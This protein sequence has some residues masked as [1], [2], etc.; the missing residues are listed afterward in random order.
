MA[1]DGVD[2]TVDILHA[3]HHARYGVDQLGR[4]AH[5]VDR[6][7]VSYTHLAQREYERAR[8][9]ANDAY[10]ARLE[11]ARQTDERA[12]ADIEAA[13]DRAKENARAA[14]DAARQAQAA[15]EGRPVTVVLGGND[16][17]GEPAPE[18]GAGPITAE[19]V[20]G[21][22]VAAE[23]VIAEPAGAGGGS[24]G[25]PEEACLLYTSRCV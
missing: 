6:K 14:A 10:E 5:R 13:L 9:S 3:E 2:I 8:Q 4:N 19:A 12:R 7:P 17:P 21:A 16:I 24:A 23:A 18:P 15:F 1:E 25:I 11:E 22:P 20:S